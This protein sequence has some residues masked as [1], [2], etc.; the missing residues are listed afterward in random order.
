M[1]P[2]R[3]TGTMGDHILMM[4]LLDG[5]YKTSVQYRTFQ[6]NFDRYGGIA[7]LLTGLNV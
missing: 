3:V 2:S 4:R 1:S 6:R 5:R 7:G